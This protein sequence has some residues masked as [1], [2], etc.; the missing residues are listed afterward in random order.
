METFS[1]KI[2][3]GTHKGFSGKKITDIVNIGIGG[4]DLGPVMVCNA[5]RHY[6][7]RLDIHF[8]SNVDATHLTQIL[9]K[10]NPETTLFIVSS[11]SF[12]TQE[13]M[14]NA[15]SAKEWFLK[16][17]KK[18]DVAQHFVAISTNKTEV[19]NFGILE[20]YNEPFLFL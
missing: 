7:T 2:I 1:E 17:A 18:E 19:K 12:S 3:S 20:E 6:K 13:T 5:L 10:L 14:T 9:Q 8:V 16:S 11:K 15:Y 4:S